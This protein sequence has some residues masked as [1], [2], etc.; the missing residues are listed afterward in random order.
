MERH[1]HLLLYLH[2]KTRFT[3]EITAKNDVFIKN[4]AE[5]YEKLGI[6]ENYLEFN[7]ES[8]EKVLL[9]VASDILIW[10]SR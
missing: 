5:H 2:F 9:L 6:S 4:N 8:S 10:D 3:E 1:F 7:Q